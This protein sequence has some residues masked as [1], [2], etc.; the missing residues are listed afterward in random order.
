MKKLSFSQIASIVIVVAAVALWLQT[1]PILPA[2]QILYKNPDLELKSLS[3]VPV[4]NA[5][6]EEIEILLNSLSSQNIYVMDV[7]SGSSLL[8]NNPDQ[9]VYPASTVKMITALVATDQFNQDDVFEVK[10]EAFTNG[11]TVGLTM[12]ESFMVKD[13][14]QA[15]L[16]ASGNDSAF[17]LADN[18]PLGYEGFV[19]AMNSQ[20]QELHLQKSSFMNPSGLDADDQYVSAHDLS[21]LAREL[22]K[23]PFL[24][25]TV[26]IKKTEISDIMG[27]S[28]YILE[29]T[30]QMLGQEGVQGMKTGTTPLA[31]EAL[32]TLLER[33][34]H[35]IIISVLKSEHRYVDT[36]TIV[37]WIDQN[38]AYN[39]LAAK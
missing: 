31:K 11:N 38:V 22:I 1:G 14:L 20:A 30:N 36:M 16:I 25:K 27:E 23:N 34:R 3:V 35:Q 18:H 6:N 26:S 4:V 39:E 15:L 10:R 8:T 24:K 29:N 19:M 9:T 13:L 7:E 37:D 32:V 21:I 12:G 33:D 17:V 2:I 28:S 5:S